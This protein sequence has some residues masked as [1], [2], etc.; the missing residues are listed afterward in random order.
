MAKYGKLCPNK[1]KRLSLVSLNKNYKCREKYFNHVTGGG[2]NVWPDSL[3][4][5]HIISPQGRRIKLQYIVPLQ[6]FKE[7]IPALNRLFSEA[8]KKSSTHCS[9]NCG[10]K[11]FL[12]A[13]PILFSVQNVSGESKFQ[14]R[15][16]FFACITS[17][18]SVDY[19]G[20][21]TTFQV[22]PAPRSRVPGRHV[23]KWSLLLLLLISLKSGD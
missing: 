20:N 8:I 19:K 18:L 22:H 9:P 7:S 12:I 5:Y 14:P 15:S 21:V 16:L 23:I 3:G 4:V 17:A 10:S 2:G 13:V 6:T 1:S 11:Y